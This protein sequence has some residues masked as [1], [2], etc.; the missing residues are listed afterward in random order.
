MA[1]E[2]VREQG[3]KAKNTILYKEK[4]K[5]KKEEEKKKGMSFILSAWLWSFD[6]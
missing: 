1:F 4:K 5:G 2:V 6:F 3:T